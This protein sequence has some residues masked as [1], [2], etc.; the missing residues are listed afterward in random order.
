VTGSWHVHLWVKGKRLNKFI[1]CEPAQIEIH[2]GFLDRTLSVNQTFDDS[3]YSRP[4]KSPKIIIQNLHLIR[5]KIF[6]NILYIWVN[7]YIYICIN[8]WITKICGLSWFRTE[9]RQ[10]PPDLSGF[11]DQKP[12]SKGELDQSMQ[13]GVNSNLYILQSIY[14]YIYTIFQSFP[15][16]ILQ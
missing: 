1:S 14:V 9:R 11:G 16:Y 6:K 5:P 12:V 8:L 13:Q 7:M 3:R 2:C 10:D 4:L 15:I